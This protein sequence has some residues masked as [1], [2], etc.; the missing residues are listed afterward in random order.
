MVVVVGLTYRGSNQA[1]CQPSEVGT[2][3]S[4][5]PLAASPLEADEPMKAPPSASEDRR[6]VQVQLTLW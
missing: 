6:E 2:P 5:S 3:V 1:T 4:V